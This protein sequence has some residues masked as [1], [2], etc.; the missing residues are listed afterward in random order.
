MNRWVSPTGI[1]MFL[2]GVSIALG[3]LLSAQTVSKA[4]V[5]MKQENCIRVKGL[6]EEKIISNHST[7]CCEIISKSGDLTNCYD[8]L[9]KSRDAVQS[10]F[11]NS[12][13][14]DVA[15]S[16]R[17]ITTEYEYRLTDKGQ[18][19][20]VLENY[21]LRQVLE[22]RTSDVKLVEAISKGVTD[23]IKNGIEISSF[24]PEYVVIGIEDIK[25][26]LLAKAT[27]NGYE[28]ANILARNSNG[29]VGKLNSASQGVF[30]ITPVNSTDVSD[31]GN[32]DTSTIEKTIKAVVTL[33]FGIE[34]GR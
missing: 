16:I 4:V 25:M 31:S 27:A 11:R 34:S 8:K 22:I 26:K 29:K 32:Y 21:I 15:V 30:Q 6:A 12:G 28:R 18:R 9:E 14:P 13:V 3:I 2:L 20:N 10:Y 24:T 33:D 23:L 5:R 19:T 1:G 17:P 7:W